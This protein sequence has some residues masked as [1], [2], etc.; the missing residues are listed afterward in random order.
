MICPMGLWYTSP[1]DE[2][3]LDDRQQR[4]T[5]FADFELNPREVRQLRRNLVRC[6]SRRLKLPVFLAVSLF[7]SIVILLNPI[8][9]FRPFKKGNT[10]EPWSPQ[11][12]CV[13]DM[14]A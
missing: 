2:P 5:T 9:I 8:L 6:A 7:A 10:Q 13:T 4:T 11:T 1:S 3:D 12:C 14:E